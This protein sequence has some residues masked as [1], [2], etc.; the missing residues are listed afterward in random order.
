MIMLKHLI[1][2][3]LFIPLACQS[4]KTQFAPKDSSKYQ[5]SLEE[6]K[7]INKNVLLSF[8][9]GEF[10]NHRVTLNPDLSN[11]EKEIILERKPNQQVFIKQATRK[12]H[13]IN[14][15]QGHNGHAKSEAF[16]AVASGYLDLLIVMDNS[17]SMG[18]FQQGVAQRLTSLLSAL[19]NVDWKIVVT[20]TSS[21][22]NFCLRKTASGVRSVTRKD[23][24]DDR[25]HALDIYREL[26]LAGTDG[27]AK[28]SGI[29]AATAAVNS[30]CEGEA[31][32]WKREG[33]DLAVLIVSDEMHCGSGPSEG[34][35][36]KAW[37]HKEYF[38]DHAPRKLSKVGVYGLLLLKRLT[39]IDPFCPLSGGYENDYPSEYIDLIESTGGIYGEICQEDYSQVLNEIS[40]DVQSRIE[41]KFQLEKVPVAGSVIVTQDGRQL[42]YTIKGSK[43]TLKGEVSSSDVEISYRHDATMV[44]KEMKVSRKMDA[45]SLEIKY[46]G[47]KI[48]D[49]KWVFDEEKGK[50]V[51]DPAP[52]ENVTVAATYKEK[53]VLNDVFSLPKDFDPESYKVKVNGMPRGDYEVDFTDH[54]LRFDTPP[55]E[56]S[57]IWL[58]W[59]KR[60]SIKDIYSPDGIPWQKVSGIEVKDAHSKESLNGYLMEKAIRVEKKDVFQDRRIHVTF[61][62]DFEEEDLSYELDLPSN[63]W[64]KKVRLS[65]DTQKG[66]CES[67]FDEVNGK[68]KVKCMS[69]D[70]SSILLEYETLEQVRTSFDVGEGRMRQRSLVLKIDGE[71][72]TLYEWNSTVVT[73]KDPR[74]RPDSKVEISILPKKK[75]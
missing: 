1:L 53:M 34:C 26:I 48:G 4:E 11:I 70:F 13:A 60:D 5:L 64:Q 18:N 46:N 38:L 49:D 39:S 44:L 29:Q 50:I 8:T 72:S 74:L 62:I 7:A 45:T 23:Y 6:K 51:F 40:K 55:A 32:D 20:T 71:L 52:P 27:N 73:I 36:G 30:A 54:V 16:S 22:D 19:S 14:W 35:A 56:G 67:F 15:Q 65:T 37:D 57:E 9:P 25:E 24:E 61:F 68:I 42:P 28:E 21:Y 47:E 69:E 59:T 3:A 2:A 12:T 66:G 58:S 17:G 10:K 41:R 31:E 43:I 75:V 33:S 63:L